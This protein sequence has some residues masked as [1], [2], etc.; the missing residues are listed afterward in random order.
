MNGE[1]DPN[2]EAP[3]PVVVAMNVN[4]GVAR[5]KQPGAPT[6]VYLSV[7]IG[8]VYLR[9]LFPPDSAEALAESLKNNA[10]QA[11]TGIVPA[12]PAEVS[13]LGGGN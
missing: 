4:V 13:A 6:Q 2:G 8:T 3:P 11:R 12:T 9:V 10:Q 7:Q 1:R 5:E